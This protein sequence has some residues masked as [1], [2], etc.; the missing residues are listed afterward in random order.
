M[1]RK[2]KRI[3]SVVLIPAVAAAALAAVLIWN[4]PAVQLGRALWKTFAAVRQSAD[5]SVY[6]DDYGAYEM[7]LYLDRQN[8]I[9]SSDQFPGEN[10]LYP[11]RKD[12][13]ESA[14]A[15]IVG[16]DSL[17]SVNSFFKLCYAVCSGRSEISTSTKRALLRD[18]R[19]L[20]IRK[21]ES[22]EIYTGEGRETCRGFTAV[23][24]G[25][26][27]KKLAADLSSDAPDA[28]IFDNVRD[29]QVTFYLSGGYVAE[30]DAVPAEGSTSR[31]VSTISFEEKGKKISFSGADNWELLLTF[32]DASFGHRHEGDVR[33]LSQMSETDI[34]SLLMRMAI[35]S[36]GISF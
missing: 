36:S 12:L 11:Y 16:A 1:S 13:S 34:F 8:L 32:S 35:R 9:L 24:T 21:V 5:L 26:F 19:A 25:D 18:L 27:L 31:T 6:T 20:R 28:A 7:N 15:N 17:S 30:A 4:S 33:D 23:I 29:T 14:L 10:L 2:K 3:L 22:K